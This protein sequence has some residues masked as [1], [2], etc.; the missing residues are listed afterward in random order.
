[1]RLF[2]QSRKVTRYLWV[3]LGMLVCVPRAGGAQSM[4]LPVEVQVPIF[5]KL[6][7]FDRNLETTAGT[8]LV[9][10]V[11]Y[12]GGNRESQQVSH[13]VET[14]LRKASKLFEGLSTR[15]LLIDLEGVDDL[16]AR[17]RQDSVQAMYVGPLRA[18][19]LRPLLKASRAAQVRSFSGVGRFVNQG[20]AMGAL[21]RGNLPE[22]VINLPAARQEGADY[23][24]QVLKLARVIE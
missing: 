24:A 7:T 5:L 9:I 1:M 17:L 23:P 2:A 12:Q 21:L 14:E 19:D 16:G 8:E 4:D 11:L 15:V 6:L 20:V 18:V 10:A 22:I 3:L 13:Q